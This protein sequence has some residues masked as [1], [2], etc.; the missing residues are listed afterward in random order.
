MLTE[1]EAVRL[2]A[3]PSYQRRRLLKAGAAFVATVAAPTSL[4]AYTDTR[5]VTLLTAWEA[6]ETP[7]VGIWQAGRLQGIALPA[8]AH[9]VLLI[10]GRKEALAVARRPGEYLLRFDLATVQPLRWADAEPERVFSGHAVFSP[11]GSTLYTTETDTLTGAGLIGVRDPIT[12]VKRAEFLTNGWGPHAALVD[13]NG[14]L[15]V[16]NGGILTLPE[17]GRHKHKLDQMDASLVKL[18]LKTGQLRGQWRLN[19][20]RL[21][22][23]HLVQASP[24]RLGIALQAEHADPAEKQRAPVLAF[25]DG[26]TLQAPALPD[27]ITFAGYGG[28]IALLHDVSTAPGPC[29]AVSSPRSDQIGLWSLEGNWIGALPARKVCGLAG[30]SKHWWAS[31]EAGDVWRNGAPSAEHNPAI[32]WDNHLTVWQRS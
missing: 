19:D 32:R 1:T 31:S 29:F 5:A 30:G 12:L 21:S 2:A 20:A 27:G 25:F 17:T 26:K 8:R 10:P 15:W 6:N 28:D 3:A 13:A 23:R 7:Y 4:S 9:E 16:A 14:S 11:D 18:D 22:I 24:N